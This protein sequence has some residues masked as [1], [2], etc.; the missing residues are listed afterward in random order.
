MPR[1][2]LVRYVIFRPKTHRLG[3]FQRFLYRRVPVAR[4]SILSGH[5][6]ALRCP[7]TGTN[8]HECGNFRR[9]LQE[10]RKGRTGCWSGLDLNFRDPSSTSPLGRMI[11]TVPETKGVT[12]AQRSVRHMGPRSVVRTFNQAF[13]WQ[14]FWLDG[15]ASSFRC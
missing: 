6:C 15:L 8:P 9:Q 5:W 4:P 2:L 3:K 1:T 13:M 12:F 10:T 7:S 14:H 11:P